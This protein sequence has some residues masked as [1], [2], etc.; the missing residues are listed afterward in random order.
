MSMNQRMQTRVEETCADL[1]GLNVA[2]KNAS[3]NKLKNLAIL[4]I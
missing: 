3:M 2:Y 4:G 1:I